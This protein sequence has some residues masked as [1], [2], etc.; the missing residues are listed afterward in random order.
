M[1][2]IDRLH[3]LMIDRDSNLPFSDDGLTLV[4]LRRWAQDT[5]YATA[6]SDENCH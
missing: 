6:S 4:I 5:V 2:F 3:V 1:A